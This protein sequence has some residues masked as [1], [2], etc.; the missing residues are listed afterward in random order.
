MPDPPFGP[1]IPLLVLAGSYLLLFAA[2]FVLP[3]R[4]S[5]RPLGG[6]LLTNALMT[7]LTFAAGGLLVRGTALRVSAWSG[8]ASFGLLHWTALPPAVEFA[9]G[10]LLI[11]LSFYWWHR[12]N[13]AVPVLWRFHNAHHVDPDLDVSTGF[14]FHPV[15]VAYSTPFRAVQ[16]AVIG[17]SPLLYVVYEIAFQVATLFHHS[18]LRLPIRLE[19][20]LNLFIVT[21]RMHGIHHSVVAEETNSNYSVI[22]RWWDALHRSLRLHIPQS[23]IEIGVP[24]YREAGDNG[25]WDLLAMPFRRQKPYWQRPDGSTPTRRE[26]ETL[27]EPSRLAE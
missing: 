15:E 24:G 8:A 11:D 2:G 6:R 4:E 26:E 17:V 25:L 9:G 21:P 18:N 12:L 7:G 13:H 27:P 14:R 5:T 1:S 20:M 10:F 16:V 23:S 22:F 3:L 19:R